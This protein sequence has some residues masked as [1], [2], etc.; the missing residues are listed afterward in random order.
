MIV[1]Q[2]KQLS[3]S[4]R[5]T[6]RL[7]LMCVLL[8]GVVAPVSAQPPG[9]E[10]LMEYTNVPMDGPVN[11]GSAVGSS[12]RTSGN[13][14]YRRGSVST[15]FRVE[16]AA[17]HWIGR[18]NSLT[19]FEAMPYVM[20]DSHIFFGDIRF[21][22]A[23][24]RDLRMGGSG[25]LGYRYFMEDFNRTIGASFYYDRDNISSVT[26]EQISLGLETL[27][28]NFDLRANFY[29]PQG[30]ES[31]L[32]NVELLG[33]TA[34]FTDFN[35]LFDR[36]R[37]ISNAME[38]FDIDLA[39][40]VAGDF[41]REHDIKIAAGYYYYDS[42]T[43]PEASGWTGR[44]QG[45]VVENLGM[46]V[47]VASDDVFD[48]NVIFGVNWSFGGATRPETRTRRADQ[49]YRLTTPVRRNFNIVVN[50]QDVIDSGLLAINPRTGSPYRVLHVASY[51]TGATPT[52]AVD[53]PFVDLSDAQVERQLNGADILFVHANS[54]YDSIAVGLNDGDVVLGEGDGINHL[55][56][57]AGF[58]EL[59]PVPRATDFAARP[60]FSNS[61]ADGVTMANRT[62]FSGFDINNPTLDGV[63]ITSVSN[64]VLDDTRI[65]N[66]GGDGVSVVNGNGAVL[67]RDV[68][69][70]N[71]DG[72]GLRVNG[73]S[74]LL[75]F[76]SVIN[77]PGR[78]IITNASEHAVLVENVTG[79]FINM[80][81]S[82][83]IDT[84]G[85]KG[86][87]IA[88]TGGAVTV[89]NLSVTGNGT[90]V[91]S[92]GIDIDGGTGIFTFRNTQIPNTLIDNVTGEAVR[93]RGGSATVNLENLTINNRNDIGIRIS[94]SYAGTTQVSGNVLIDTP[95]AGTP[96]NDAGILFENTT[97]SAAFLG[98]VII[99]GT[100]GPGNGIRIGDATG[101][102]AP[103]A[104]TGS[105]GVGG[106]TSITSAGGASIL[107]QR[108]SANVSFNGTT[109]INRQDR[110]ILI[111]DVREILNAGLPPEDALGR[112]TTNLINFNGQNLIGNASASAVPAI[113]IQNANSQIA[114]GT[115]FA[116]NTT[117]AP[118]VN[119]LDNP[120][121]SSTFGRTISFG[122]L[123]ITSNAGT[124][125]FA[126]NN[127]LTILTTGSGTINSTGARAVDLENT[128]TNVTLTSVTAT[129]AAAPTEGIRLVNITNP[130]SQPFNF[131]VIGDGTGTN[132]N[133][134]GVI[135]GWTGAGNQGAFIQDA[136]S[137]NLQAMSFNNNRTHVESLQTAANRNT[138]QTVRV[139]LS[140]GTNSQEHGFDFND[141][142]TIQ[143]VNSTFTGNGAADFETIRMTAGSV[144]DYEWTVTG[145]TI[146]D[147][148]ADA[149]A[150]PGA[151]AAPTST[152]IL[153]VSNNNITN[154]RNN[155]S[156]ITMDWDGTVTATIADNLFTHTGGGGGA[157]TDPGI[158]NLV[159]RS[160]DPLDELATLAIT[161]NTFNTTAGGNKGL[162]IVTNNR[163]L[164][165][166]TA[167][168]MTLGGG[169]GNANGSNIG[170]Q[171]DLGASS[172]TFVNFNV[173]NDA[174]EGT[175]VLFD[176]VVAPA[177]VTMSGNEINI[178]G[179]FG[180]NIERGIIFQAVTGQ[181]DL[182]SA[183]NN[184]VNIFNFGGP[185]TFFFIPPGANNG[186]LEINGFLVP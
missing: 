131:Q 124:G 66:A 141:T 125:L 38:G 126:N 156:S 181:V 77:E 19:I 176:R 71:A 144:R 94:D 168:N 103:F 17:G 136:G 173:I 184:I 37:T 145:N 51:A 73:G 163:S 10:P 166:I 117:G 55:I 140:N 164:N 153:N 179:G 105:F 25:G 50:D 67:M 169:I 24:T 35:I 20:E 3:S 162:R 118:G 79:G 49:H 92:H 47:E 114:F 40:P 109:I 33:D 171:F 148:T 142:D 31:K 6:C 44:L 86:V 107:I 60:I 102:T 185:A 58:T 116:T 134:G 11:S 63:D 143:I 127:P 135:S 183:T 178:N 36:R 165:T 157:S 53:N 147:A 27:G 149:I 108:S 174:S 159:T 69:I 182:F 154:S 45:D 150:I 111:Q 88:N 43:T 13:V 48:T 8:G 180:G 23:G 101:S 99:N 78:G 91:D 146:T 83:V 16:H 30:N 5:L 75:A 4:L 7:T 21:S 14:D 97:G 62:E 80:A 56:P 129:G 81:G 177:A 175:G 70:T 76:T 130:L 9:G 61:G 39:V 128:G 122:A 115:V 151:P 29:K 15:L 87:R 1:F 65:I 18:R 139:A 121:T 160:T 54:T 98:N 172:N 170:M 90:T 137:V 186:Q 106:T 32:S 123:N 89:D 82:S 110:G 132:N 120:G 28:E 46:R 2:N 96:T 155:D 112:P 167:N 42:S 100:R 119:I 68:E 95:T 41:A 12:P 84:A 22:R 161:R 74:P 34:R 133:S 93:I 59:L 85:G 113:D 138:D 57:V 104:T 72:V 64:V 158:I 26:F 152:L 52:G